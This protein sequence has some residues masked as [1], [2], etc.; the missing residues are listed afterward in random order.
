MTITI[1]LFSFTYSAEVFPLSH[2]EVGMSWAVAQCLGW[3]TVLS[4]TFPLMLRALGVVGSFGIY[5]GFNILALV[6]IF[7]WVPETKQRTLEELDYVFGVKTNVFVRY[8]WSTALPWWFK[9]YVLFQKNAVLPP[10]YHFDMEG[11]HSEDSDSGSEEK[12]KVENK[13]DTTVKNSGFQ[14]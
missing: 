12:V 1:L 10:L 9:R 3:A 11:S 14:S 6:M 4:L 7:C 2:R 8:Q 13:E 5:A